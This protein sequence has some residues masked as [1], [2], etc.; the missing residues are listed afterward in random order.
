M[1][2]F[3]LFA[4]LTVCAA[5][6]VATAC[7]N[8][9][10]PR[11]GVESA[12]SFSNGLKLGQCF[13]QVGD[14]A[15]R[16]VPPGEDG[17]ATVSAPTGEVVTRVAIKAG[18]PCWFTPEGATGTSTIDMGGVPCYVVSGLGT[19]TAIVTR[20]GAGP[21]CKDISHV[22]SVSGVPAPTT[23]LLQICVTVVGDNPPPSTLVDPYTFFVAGQQI[24]VAHAHCATPIELSAGAVTITEQTPLFVGFSN[25]VS[26]PDGRVVSVDVPG[27]SATVTVVAGSTTVI[28]ITNLWV[29]DPGED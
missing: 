2:P 18:T 26:V 4:A 23:G 22:E 16:Q 28:T 25:A 15:A 8:T 7:D 10:A 9:V 19:A 20:V 21:V 13:L 24:D 17:N 6:L 3:P 12:A 14:A 29:P 1:R 27:R 11:P 5:T